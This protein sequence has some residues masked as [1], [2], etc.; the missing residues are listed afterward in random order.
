M[1]SLSLVGS[2]GSE[3]QRNYV[4]VETWLNFSTDNSTRAAVKMLGYY[5]H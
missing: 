2:N 4:T 3:A 1:H 5:G